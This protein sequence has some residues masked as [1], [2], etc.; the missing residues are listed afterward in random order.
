MLPHKNVATLVAAASHPILRDV[1]L[2]LA[3]P[4][5]ERERRRIAAMDRSK[6]GDAGVKHV[7]FVDAECLADLYAGAALV[8]LPSLY[9]GFGLPLLEAMRYGVPAVASLIPAHREVGGD[10][11]V[12]VDDPLNSTAWAHAL[13]SV[14]HD[15]EL[16]ERLSTRGSRRAAGVTWETIAE[17]MVELARDVAWGRP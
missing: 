3:G 6:I 10:A 8:A 11:V 17:E 5:D 7:G 9:E 1:E 16:S 2:I 4:V 14:I 15:E 13:S 12:Y